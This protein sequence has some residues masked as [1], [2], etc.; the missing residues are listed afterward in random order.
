[1]IFPGMEM[2]S[3]K[4]RVLRTHRTSQSGQSLMFLIALHKEAVGKNG[5]EKRS[6][7][8]LPARG[9]SGSEREQSPSP[10]LKAICENISMPI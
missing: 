6:V 3:C 10:A 7:Q 9:W 4:K 1:M 8:K 5:R 2:P